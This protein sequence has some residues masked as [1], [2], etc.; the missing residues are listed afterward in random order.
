M[1]NIDDYVTYSVYEYYMVSAKDTLVKKA[2]AEKDLTLFIKGLEKHLNELGLEPKI[3][4]YQKVTNLV[5][6]FLVLCEEDVIPH[7]KEYEG[8]VSI[9]KEESMGG[10]VERAKQ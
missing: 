1:S 9:I 7:I 8:I 10:R 6:R 3:K 2:T 4:G 5:P